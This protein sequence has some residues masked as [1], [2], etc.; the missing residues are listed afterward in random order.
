MILSVFAYSL[1]FGWQYAVGFVV[2]I[3]VHEMGHYLAARQRG[4][5]VGLPTFIP[6]L[7]AWIELKDRPHDVET[8]AY[9]G[10]AVPLVGTIGAL[11][12]YYV[13]RDEGSPLLLALA[14]SG[15]FLNLFNMIPISPFDGGRVSAVLSPRIWFVGVPV[16]VAMF[17]YIP[18][19]MLLIV[20]FLA[21]PQLIAA[22]RFDPDAPEN[23]A[24]YSISS[25]DR[26]T[27]AL[28]YIGLTAFLATMVHHL[29]ET[30]GSMGYR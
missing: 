15:F 30:L 13:A 23:V 4:L 26:F 17:L 20:A 9:I 25:E 1:V 16:L 10:L 19:P 7:G 29:H 21:W 3:F 11:A 27:Y 18:S 28:A 8:E 6:F 5:D 22:W 12:C 2:L 24:Y 14:Y